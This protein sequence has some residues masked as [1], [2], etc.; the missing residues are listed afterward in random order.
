MDFHFVTSNTRENNERGGVDTRKFFKLIRQFLP[1]FLLAAFLPVLLA[2]MI[3]PTDTG[4]V[5]RADTDPLLRVWVEP[6]TSIITG[7]GE[8]RLTLYAQF[9]SET[10]LIPELQVAVTSGEAL[11]LSESEFVYPRPF[12]GKVEL[13]KFSVSSSQPG[14]YTISV[15]QSEVIVRAY[16]GPIEIKTNTARV[17]V[18]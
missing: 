10:K 2:L 18:Q 1:V 14:D 3:R 13:G 5:T 7:D 4:F 12:K 17:I 9:E 6:T 8:A 11:V 16:E 15:P